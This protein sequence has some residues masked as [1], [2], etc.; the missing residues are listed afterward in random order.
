MGLTR[1]AELVVLM[2]KTGTQ[3]FGGENGRNVSHVSVGGRIILKR[4]FKK[5]N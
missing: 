2:G 1:W 5:D 3:G 4:I